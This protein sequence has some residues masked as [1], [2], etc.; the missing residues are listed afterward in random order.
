MTILAKIG[1]Q[2]LSD[3]FLFCQK[4]ALIKHYAASNHTRIDG[5]R[6]KVRNPLW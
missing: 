1:Q 5:D 4:Y 6:Q 2:V 3:H